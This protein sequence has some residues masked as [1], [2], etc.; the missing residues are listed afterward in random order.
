MIL[1]CRKGRRHSPASPQPASQCLA[2]K[3]PERSAARSFAC[4]PTRPPTRQPIRCSHPLRGLTTHSYDSEPRQTQASAIAMRT[5]MAS[6]PAPLYC[7]AYASGSNQ[8]NFFGRHVPVF[9]IGM[10][11]P[12]LQSLRR[13]ATNGRLHERQ[14]QCRTCA[15]ERRQETSEAQRADRRFLPRGLAFAAHFR[16]EPAAAR[17]RFQWSSSSP[18]SRRTS[19]ISRST[20]RG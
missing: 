1:P 2:R 10:R 16:P 6:R 8:H 19:L 18:S 20:S 3:P 14:G 9:L 5:R 12:R 11:G 7:P 15:S 4:E 17:F 13:P